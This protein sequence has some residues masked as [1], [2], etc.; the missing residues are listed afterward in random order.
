M[1]LGKKF[2]RKGK[3]R[4]KAIETSYQVLRRERGRY[5]GWENEGKRERE[6]RRLR[7]FLSLYLLVGGGM[8]SID[9]YLNL[10]I[11]KQQ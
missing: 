5:R 4:L 3:K 8:G 2:K 11:G 1:I 10:L 9:Q 7:I 6:S